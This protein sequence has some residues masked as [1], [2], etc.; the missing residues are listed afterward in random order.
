MAFLV[1]CL[2]YMCNNVF[3]VFLPLEDLLFWCLRL[4]KPLPTTAN[5]GKRSLS[6]VR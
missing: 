3:L 4:E 2:A 5:G 1:A 6:S